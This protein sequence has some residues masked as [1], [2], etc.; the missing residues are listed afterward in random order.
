MNEVTIELGWARIVIKEN[1]VEI[2]TSDAAVTERY[3]GGWPVGQLEGQS[4]VTRPKA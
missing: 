1:E 3:I 4:F 2:L